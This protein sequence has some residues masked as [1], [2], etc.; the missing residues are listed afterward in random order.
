MY[1]RDLTN[2]HH[3]IDGRGKNANFSNT[4]YLDNNYI[5]HKVGWE[6]KS[7]AIIKYLVFHCCFL[8]FSFTFFPFPIIIVFKS[9]YCCCTF[10]LNRPF[11]CI[12][13]NPPVIYG[14]NQ[15]WSI[16]VIHLLEQ[17]ISHKIIIYWTA[18]LP[19]SPSNV[20]G[21]QKYDLEWNRKE[22]CWVSGSLPTTYL[23]CFG[24][25]VN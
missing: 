22:S 4:P 7:F 18:S 9:Y 6:K 5:P 24:E 13:N 23:M 16:A 15:N 25:F 19:E 10:I 1:F 17:H 12:F 3:S 2:N 21:N 14:D 8:F 20:Y 11:T